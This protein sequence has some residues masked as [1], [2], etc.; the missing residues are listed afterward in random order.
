MPT[1]FCWLLVQPVSEELK[2]LLGGSLC[3]TES[4]ST[5]SHC[6]PTPSGFRASVLMTRDDAVT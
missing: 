4:G 5:V 6:Q 3:E 1:T 2:T